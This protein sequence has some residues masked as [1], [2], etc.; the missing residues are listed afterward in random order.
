[1]EYAYEAVLIVGISLATK[2][3]ASVSGL[4]KP[5]KPPFKTSAEKAPPPALLLLA[6]GG[7]PNV[8]DDDE[9]EIIEDT[10]VSL[11]KPPGMEANGH[12]G[13]R[14]FMDAFIWWLGSHTGAA[15]PTQVPGIAVELENHFSKKVPVRFLRFEV[16]T[17]TRDIYP[18]FTDRMS[19]GCVQ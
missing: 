4:S 18:S 2:P 16:G 5:F 12:N 9:I 3:F 14:E 1:M 8:E 15:P 11:A 10:S 13:L 17:L 6:G 7:Q 19:L